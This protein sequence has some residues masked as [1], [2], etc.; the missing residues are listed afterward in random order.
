M[1]TPVS[2]SL[3]WLSLWHLQLCLTEG[4]AGL[5]IVQ[6]SFI[7][8]IDLKLEIFT[9]FPFYLIRFCSGSVFEL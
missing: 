8:R 6:S 4:V 5:E 3:G 9:T 7:V 2:W 1:L